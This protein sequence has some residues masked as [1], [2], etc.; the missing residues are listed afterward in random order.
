MSPTRPART[1]EPTPE[2]DRPSGTVAPVKRVLALAVAVAMVVGAFLVRSQVI[3]HKDSSPAKSNGPAHGSVLTVGC[4]PELADVCAAAA[5]KGLEVFTDPVDL[6]N[7]ATAASTID[8]WLTYGPA[9]GMVNAEASGQAKA[10]GSG[11]VL[12]S[13]RLAVLAPADRALA[14][15][16]HCR[17]LKLSWRCLVQSAGVSWSTIA[18][19]N[20]QLGGTVKV[21]V[22]DP[23]SALGAV[24]VGPMALATSGQSDP[25]IEDID[26]NGVTR[27]VASVDQLPAGD[28][29]NALTLQGPAAYSTVVAPEGAAKRAA[30]STRGQ[31]L[32]LTVIYPDPVARTVVVL[33]PPAGGDVPQAMREAF[34]RPAVRDALTKAGWSPATTGATSGLPAS[35][36]LFALRKG[37]AP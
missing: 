34:D 11:T 29:L 16:K 7:A 33:S 36:V 37:L 5:G 13:G 14:L 12:A 30:G 19:A 10:Y 25:G 24:L 1:A 6:D 3:E 15:A 21:G 18:P 31:G 9:P 20:P 8:A 22:G 17:L 32:N 28:E 27:A 26:T 35:D 2:P 23:A 4:A